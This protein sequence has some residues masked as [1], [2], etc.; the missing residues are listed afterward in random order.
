MPDK[1]KVSVIIP[2]FNE[3][4]SIEIL[5]DSLLCQSFKA[6]EIVIC[7]GGSSDK[8]LEIIKKYANTNAEIKITPKQSTCRGSGRNYAIQYT[9]NDLVA[10]IDAGTTPNKKWLEKLV[11]A[12]FRKT[13]VNVVYGAAKPLV[14]NYFSRNIS[15]IIIGRNHLNGKI[16][17]TV[18]SM[19][20]EKLVWK[21]VDKFPESQDGN[22]VVED[23]IFLEKIKKSKFLTSIEENAIVHWEVPTQFQKCF[24]RFS[25]QS[26]DALNSGYT[27]S[28]HQGLFRNLFIF[29]IVIILGFKFNHLFFYLLLILLFIRSYSY[30]RT[31][32][33]YIKRKAI[34]LS[35]LCV[36]SILLCWVDLATFY[37]FIKFFQINF[38]KRVNSKL[39]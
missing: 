31:M 30:V 32:P 17:P 26:V 7:D 4:S 16:I 15:N 6:D 27:K 39:S 2:T 23:L 34:L 37:G 25:A 1:V 18:A 38:T 11:K 33:I 3:D 14:S 28:L 13:N 12:K 8:T 36:T 5:L 35:D 21:E 22:Y 10:L 9:K 29:L 20:L 24:T 19:L